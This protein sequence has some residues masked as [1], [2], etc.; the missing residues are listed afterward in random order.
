MTV[1]LE[2]RTYRGKIYDSKRRMQ[3]VILTCC[4]RESEGHN[5]FHHCFPPLGEEGW[6]FKID[7]NNKKLIVN[8]HRRSRHERLSLIP[9]SH[10]D[11]DVY[12]Y[13]P[14]IGRMVNRAT[15]MVTNVMPQVRIQEIWLLFRFVVYGFC[16]AVFPGNPPRLTARKWPTTLTVF[17]QWSLWRRSGILGHSVPSRRDGLRLDVNREGQVRAIYTVIRPQAEVR[18]TVHVIRYV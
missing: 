4:R 6:P 13:L 11:I 16:L 5:F 15:V 10:L 14:W 8:T 17:V 12:V 9:T 7:A 2:G 3:S 18:V 1:I